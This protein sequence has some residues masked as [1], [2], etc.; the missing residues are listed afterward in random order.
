MSRD[1]NR[2][3]LEKVTF[4]ELLERLIHENITYRGNLAVTAPEE[5][6]R[7]TLEYQQRTQS[8]R[9]ELNRREVIY[10]KYYES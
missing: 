1:P 5:R 4:S 2:N 6:E 7:V 9:D 8:L 3:D 10:L